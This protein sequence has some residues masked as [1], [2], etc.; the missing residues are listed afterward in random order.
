MDSKKFRRTPVTHQQSYTRHHNFARDSRTNTVTTLNPYNYTGYFNNNLRNT[1]TRNQDSY[2]NSIPTTS[3]L[4]I[5]KYNP[6]QHEGYTFNENTKHNALNL[7][8]AMRAATNS[9]IPHIKTIQT[10]KAQ[11]A[12]W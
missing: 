2:K 1:P 8:K 9:S 10:K 3:K 12:F 11:K 5:V 6:H 7:S 4:A